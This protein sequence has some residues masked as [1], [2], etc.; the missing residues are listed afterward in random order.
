MLFETQIS[1]AHDVWLSYPVVLKFCTED[2]SDIIVLSAT[3]QN[4]WTN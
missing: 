3:F 4:D 1:L 2:D